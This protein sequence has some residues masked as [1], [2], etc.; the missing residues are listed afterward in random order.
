MHALPHH[1]PVVEHVDALGVHDVCQAVTD[2]KHGVR[3]RQPAHGGHDGLLAL[4]VNV[5][6]GLVEDVD[7]RVMQDGAGKGE[8]LALAAGEVGGALG[9]ARLQPVLPAQEP[10]EVGHL[11]RAPELVIRGVGRSHEQVVT[12]GAGK[13]VGAKAHIG[14]VA[15]KRRRVKVTH[16]P[17]AQEDVTRVARLTPREQGGDG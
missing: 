11:E 7:G 9:E 12:H 6:C 4:H 3:A 10:G 8:A 1:A 2:E 16:L 17:A 13:E 14:H 5:A 15:G